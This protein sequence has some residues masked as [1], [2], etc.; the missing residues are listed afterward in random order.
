MFS[1]DGSR[2]VA[3]YIDETR[4]E[5][6]DRRPEQRFDRL[7]FTLELIGLLG[8]QALR[9]AVFRSKRLQVTQGRDLGRG[10]DARW[11]MVGVPKDASA[12]SIAL[13]LTAIHVGAGAPYALDAMLVQAKNQASVS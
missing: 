10:P 1:I 4:G 2:N 8:P 3:P 11:A 12:E 7:A 13:A 6:F 5:N 9:V